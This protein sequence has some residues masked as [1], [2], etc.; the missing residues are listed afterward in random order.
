MGHG[1]QQLL[2]TVGWTEITGQLNVEW[3]SMYT[4][5]KVMSKWLTRPE[6]LM[7]ITSHPVTG[8]PMT[9]ELANKL[10]QGIFF[11]YEL[12]RGMILTYELIQ[13]IILA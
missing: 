7:S 5:S 2:T 13:G 3:D 1:L 11:A 9:E 8:K 12:I 10:I 6:V 4:V